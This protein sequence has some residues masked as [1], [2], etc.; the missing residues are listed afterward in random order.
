MEGVFSSFED[1][2]AA[3]LSLKIS[4]SHCCTQ[5][6]EKLGQSGKCIYQALKGAYPPRLKAIKNGMIVTKPFPVRR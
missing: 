1:S 4:R 6:L 3:I 5:I 2:G